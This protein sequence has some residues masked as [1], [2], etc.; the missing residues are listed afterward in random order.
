MRFPPS[1][2][3][4]CPSV[5]IIDLS[6]LN[7]VKKILTSKPFDSFL[8]EPI[9]LNLP[10]KINSLWDDNKGEQDMI[11][12]ILENLEHESKGYIKPTLFAANLCKDEKPTTKLKDLPLHLE[13]A[14]LDNNLEF[15][16]IISS[17]LSA[18]EK[19]LLLGVLSK[20]K[21]ALAWKVTDI[22]GISPSFCTH[23]ILMEDN[24]KSIVQTQCRLNPKVQDVEKAEI[25]KLL[26]VGV[27]YA[28][29]ESLWDKCHFVVREG[30]VLGHKISKAGIEEQTND[31]PV[32]IA[33]KWDLDF[34]LICDAS[35]YAVGAVLGQGIDK[36]FRP[37]Y[38]ASKT[39]NDAQEHHSTTEKEL[40]AVVYAFD[41]FSL[42]VIPT[43]VL[44]EI[45][46]LSSKTKIP[47]VMK[48]FFEQQIAKEEAFTKYILDKIADVK[49]SLTRVRTTICEMESKSDKDA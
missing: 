44:D 29:F 27:I 6:I 24:F 5:D 38:Y 30:I 32:I 20:H 14:F 18:Q 23:K 4:T 13:Y 8:F 19:E 1:D 7:H 16:I 25:V 42:N 31:C 17:L 33:P 40:L 45:I 2:D 35:D 22:K 49:A 39:I 34:E 21:N 41:K 12:H 10:T 15:P 46:A 11:N 3:D 37:I 47:K 9:N 43:P 36:K 28:I 48:I 26:D